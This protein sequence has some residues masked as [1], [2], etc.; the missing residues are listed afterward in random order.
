MKTDT[1]SPRIFSFNC[2][3]ALPVDIEKHVAAFRHRGLDRPAR[4]SIEVFVDFRPF[5]QFFIVAQK[6]E[7]VARAEKI[8]DVFYLACPARARGRADGEF[9]TRILLFQKV[10]R[11][12]GFAGA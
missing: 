8:M 2:L 3:G 12:G 11:D 9:E 7:I 4:C 1:M 6:L 10:A 5:Q